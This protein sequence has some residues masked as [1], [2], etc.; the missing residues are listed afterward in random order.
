MLDPIPTY[1]LKECIDILLP[2]IT[3]IINLS[4]Q[5][6]IVP[7]S[8]KTAAVTPLLKK[9]SLDANVL[10]NFRPVSNLPFISKILEKVVLQQI[11]KHKAANNLNEKFQSAYR[12]HHSTETALLRIQNDLLQSMHKKQCCF[13]VL[14]DLSAPFD[15]VNHSILVDR[16]SGR[17]GIRGDA[18][19]WIQSYLS[20]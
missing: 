3:R 15:T 1:L 14:L 13:L 20:S 7:D 11:N 8:F 2:T 5:F 4:L 9:A 19:K 12:K 17:F 16:L 10:K 6:C 18:S